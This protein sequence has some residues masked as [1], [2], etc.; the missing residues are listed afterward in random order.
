MFLF[1]VGDLVLV[2]RQAHGGQ[3]SI[4]GSQFFL[5]IMWVRSLEHSVSL[6]GKHL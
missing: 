5:C 2:P 1:C 6:S 4:A 3:R